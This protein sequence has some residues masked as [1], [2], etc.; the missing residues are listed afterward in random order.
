MTWDNKRLEALTAKLE[1]SKFDE[2]TIFMISQLDPEWVKKLM[3][4]MK[5]VND[6]EESL[7]DDM[8]QITIDEIKDGH[9]Y[10]VTIETMEASGLGET[11]VYT[12]SLY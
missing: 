2:T 12:R 6:F 4:C 1:E 3:L 7:C 5:L 8:K 10:G 11:E 9:E